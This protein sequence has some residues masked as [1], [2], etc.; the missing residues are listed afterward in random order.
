MLLSILIP[1]YNEEKT[2]LKL[3]QLV[4]YQKKKINLE[5]LICD[6]GSNDLTHEILVK[7]NTMYDVLLTNT[8]NAGK[9]NAIKNLIKIAKGEIILIQDADLE[10][11][12]GDY[13]A[14]IEPIVSK[15][16]N[17]VYGSRILGMPSRYQNS[18]F[19]SMFRILGNH[20]LTIVSNKINNQ[21]LTDAHTC[22]KVFSKNIFNKLSLEHD[23]FSFCPE[24]TT[25]ISKL[26]EKIVEVPISYAG[27]GFEEGKKIGYKDF[28]IAIYT[29]IKFR[30]IK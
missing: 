27:R 24:V 9:G 11:D 14:L 22:Y 4:N 30:L 17:V 19:T 26:G 2:I 3:L 5:I 15:K 29:L 8:K 18:N 21:N 20:L 7:N 16:S 10:Y 1:A 28:F 12:P 13:P 23:D 25:K 6:D